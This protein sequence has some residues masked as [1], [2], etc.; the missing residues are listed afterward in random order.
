[1]PIYNT[2]AEGL[3]DANGVVIVK[4]AT[5]P[6]ANQALVAVDANTATWQTLATGNGSVIQTAF[7]HVT[8]DISTTSSTFVDMTSQSIT[9]TTGANAIFAWWQA[10]VS[11]STA[12]GVANFNLLLDGV[13]QAGGSAKPGGSS[14]I[15]TGLI[16]RFAVTAGTHTIKIQ[17]NVSS[18]TL[19]CLAATQPSTQSGALMIMEVV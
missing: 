7:A 10:S 8:T 3:I 4:D 12:G 9:I 1:M 2:Y 18:G 5:A 14:S 19:S 17:W 6:T 16:H 11:T 13:N 15:S